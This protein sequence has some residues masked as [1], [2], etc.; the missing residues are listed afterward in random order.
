[1][2]TTPTL[3]GLITSFYG[4]KRKKKKKKKK[5]E[6]KKFYIFFYTT[7]KNVTITIASVLER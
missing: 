3:V 4:K 7:T 6:E 1:M 2:D 5:K